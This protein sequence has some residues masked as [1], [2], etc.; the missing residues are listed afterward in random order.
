MH[1]VVWVLLDYA[2]TTTPGDLANLV[3]TGVMP[4]LLDNLEAAEA[5]GKNQQIIEILGKIGAVA[6]NDCA[7]VVREAGA[8]PKVLQYCHGANPLDLQRAA[9]LAIK[10]MAAK[11]GESGLDVCRPCC[12]VLCDLVSNANTDAEV[13]VN[14]CAALSAIS[15]G[16][17]DILKV[18]ADTG[19]FVRLVDLLSS[20]PVEQ[21]RNEALRTIGNIATGCSR[22]AALVVRH[23]AL[24]ILRSLLKSPQ[25][26]QR[27]E[28]CWTIANLAADSPFCIEAIM[29][30]NIVPALIDLLAAEEDI[31]VRQEAFWAISSSINTGTRDQ[32]IGFEQQEVVQVL[33]DALVRESPG[34][35]INEC[36]QALNRLMQRRAGEERGLNGP[37]TIRGFV[38]EAISLENLEELRERDKDERDHYILELD[39]F[40]ETLDEN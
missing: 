27:K 26:R 2:A 36:L 28:A 25:V 40:E 10:H 33:C 35:L 30:N 12:V 16:P 32:L 4:F 9:T 3:A 14:A 8:M 13:L 22:E 5:S 20:H 38:S 23:N 17:N 19:I 7:P 15:G 24:P 29:D 11:P 18:I 39:D 31:K 1:P 6:A 21:I 37:D 34:A